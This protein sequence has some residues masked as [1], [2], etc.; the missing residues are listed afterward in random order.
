MPYVPT[1][2]QILSFVSFGIASYFSL[3]FIFGYSTYHR[4]WP[5]AMPILIGFSILSGWLFNIMKLH[6]FFFWWLIFM[7]YIFYRWHRA[8]TLSA[9]EILAYTKGVAQSAGTDETLILKSY[10][11]TKKF[12]LI[13]IFCYL[14]FFSASYLYLYNR[15]F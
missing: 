15:A 3:R 2:S 12:L 1:I 6:G 8:N 7:V 13:S 11:N 14:L 4:F 10:L 9:E 5:V